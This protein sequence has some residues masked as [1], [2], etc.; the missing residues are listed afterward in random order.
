[1]GMAALDACIYTLIAILG[2]A[3]PILLQVISRLD[4]KYSSARA[5]GLFEQEPERKGFVF[6]LKL[7]ALVAGIWF[8]RFP[9]PTTLLGHGFLSAVVANSAL[10]LVYLTSVALL[11]L[12]FLL[13]EKIITYYNTQKFSAY[14]Q[15]KHRQNRADK[16]HV[17]ILTDV[18]LAVISARNSPVA[19]QI[20]EFLTEEFDWERTEAGTNEVTYSSVYYQ[21]TYRTTEELA[22][23]GNRKDKSLAHQAAGG[24]WLLGNSAQHAISEF[25]YSALWRNLLLALEYEQ[26]DMVYDYWR[27]AYRYLEQYL[28]AIARQY[29]TADAALRVT[30]T[31]AITLREQQRDRFWEFQHAV[32]AVLLYL[33]KA[34]LLRKLWGYTTSQPPHF[35]LLPTHTTEIFTAF[36]RYHDTFRLWPPVDVRYP[37]PNEAGVGSE[38][39]ISNW[40]CRYLAVLF[41]RQYTLQSTLVGYEP[42]AYPVLPADQSDKQR[43]LDSLPYFRRLVTQVLHEPQLLRELHLDFLTEAWCHDQRADYPLA[44][45]DKLA[46][47]LTAAFQRDAAELPLDQGQ[48]AEFYQDSG[49]ILEMA[50]A[51]VQSLALAPGADTPSFEEARYLRGMH[52]LVEK[53]A[54][55]ARP[56]VTNLTFST[57]SAGQLRRG[58][59]DRV[60]AFFIQRETAVY[61][62]ARPEVFAALDK[63]AIDSSYLIINLSVNL[64]RAAS[65]SAV[66]GYSPESYRG[67]EILNF[68]INDYPDSL[69]VIRR[70][71]LPQLHFLPLDPA[72]VARYQLTRI[73]ERFPLYGSVLDANKLSAEVAAE[74]HRGDFGHFSQTQVAAQAL[75]TLELLLEMQWQIGV[76]L[77]RLYCYD[78]TTSHNFNDDLEAITPL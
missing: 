32:G 74:L 57:F 63:L 11:V 41:L 62:I 7:S 15:Q 42:L 58:L 56:V 23:L 77:V 45:I 44:F 78:P 75:E 12:F 69:L 6:L 61:M 53:D 50:V 70:S 59:R 4:D 48:V 16:R 35:W 31:D 19:Q 27:T 29:E 55:S 20:A 9:P 37:F 39:I 52:R 18:F 2:I 54:Y 10:L 24:S 13:T 22:Q 28:P 3:Y 76:Q 49:R 60:A 17:E 64:G 67:T 73:S 33:E 26:E 5:V 65:E 1:M 8:C 72:A 47:Q 38:G 51:D 30:N 34:K 14:L 43:W 71:A 25:T 66:E 21:L 36:A 46:Q 68:S 40:L